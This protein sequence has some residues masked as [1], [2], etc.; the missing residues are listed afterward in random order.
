MQYRN[1]KNKFRAIFRKSKDNKEEIR[2]INKQE[3]RVYNSSFA[4]QIET[5]DSDWMLLNYA[6]TQIKVGYDFDDS[7][8]RAIYPYRMQVGYEFELQN[9]REEILKFMTITPIL[10][11]EQ[12][13]EGQLKIQTLEHIDDFWIDKEINRINKEEDEDGF[14][15]YLIKGKIN[16]QINSDYLP[17]DG[18]DGVPFYAKFLVTFLNPGAFYEISP[19]KE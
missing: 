3:V 6:L 16:V 15:N 4:K 1:T 18:N 8:D 5:F 14:N 12:A 11:T 17:I 10:R 9:V 7:E 19:D 2:R 13:Y